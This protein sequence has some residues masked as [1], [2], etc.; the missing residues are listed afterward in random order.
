M[1]SLLL[2]IPALFFVFVVHAQAYP[3]PEFSNEVYY[4]KKDTG[5]SAMRL[6]KGSSKIEAKTKMGG[7]GGSENG[8]SLNG[9][10]SGIHITNGTN[11]SFVFSTR[12]SVRQSSPESDST[13]Q[14]NGIDPA[15]MNLSM[16]SMMDPAS[17]IKLYKAEAAKGKRKI[18][19]QKVPGV[20]VLGGNK[21]KS[22]ATYSFSVKK[23]REGYW[24]LVID[25]ALPSGEYA[26]AVLSMGMSNIDGETALYAFAVD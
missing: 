15:M 5:I 21:T 3:E 9:E 10:G 12:A 16:S 17:M 22:A 7:F 1:K 4:L 11:L 14:A 26:F 19:M 20:M 18:I 13:M 24:E 6:E 25:Q 23:I 8:Y 2:A